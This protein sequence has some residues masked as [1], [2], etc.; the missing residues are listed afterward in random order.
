MLSPADLPGRTSS[1]PDSDSLSQR[2]HRHRLTTCATSAL[3]TP[4]LTRSRVTLRKLPHR[5]LRHVFIGLSIPAALIAGTVLPAAQPTA[6]AAQPVAA[7]YAVQGA[8]QLSQGDRP[9]AETD[10]SLAF[11]TNADDPALVQDEI[12]LTLGHPGPSPVSVG[13]T[14]DDNV[15]L[16]RGP[17]TDHAVITKLSKGTK[18]EVLDGTNGWYRVATASGTVGW[19]ADD[20]FDVDSPRVS[21]ATT[22][23]QVLTGTITDDGVHVR[24]GPGTRYN[25]Y[26]K[27]AGGTPVQVLARN[28]RWFKI[29]SPRGT[30]GWVSSDLMSMSDDTARKVPITKDVPPAPKP[31]PVEVTPVP[32]VSPAQPSQPA[33]AI[34]GDAAAIALQYVGARYVYGGASPRGF[35]CS[36]LTLYVYK[37]LGLNLPH[38]ASLQYNTPGQ[39]IGSLDALQPGDLVFFVRT[40][41]ANGITHVGL[42]TGNGMMVTAGTERT[43]VQH[44]SVYGQYWQS[45]FVGGVRPAR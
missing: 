32:N 41:P 34:S 13:A 23:A 11:G 29:R 31:Q 4:M 33:A 18:L 44:V 24:Q 36:G 9:M 2:V 8:L 19:V 21:A 43:G 20:Y 42:Y 26:G 10:A 16:R 45:R 27:L 12:A 5:Y 35:D 17:S 28:G 39:R 6:V 1:T 30:V 3:L 15:N 7:A 22:S 38:K 37:Q 14:T 40:T 25:S